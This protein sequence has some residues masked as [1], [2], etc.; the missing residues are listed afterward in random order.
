MRQH[1]GCYR[2][3][4]RRVP[5]VLRLECQVT[6]LREFALNGTGHAAHREQNSMI[7]RYI[8]GREPPHRRPRLCRILKRATAA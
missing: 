2:R 8:A 1:R 6:E 4:A 7:R 5:A 3:A